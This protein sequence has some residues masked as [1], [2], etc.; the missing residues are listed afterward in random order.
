[1]RQQRHSID[2]PVDPIY[3]LLIQQMGDNSYGVLPEKASGR[4]VSNVL[5]DMRFTTEIEPEQVSQIESKSWWIQSSVV[6]LHH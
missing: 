5:L 2:A 4:F 1:M 6:Y 3:H